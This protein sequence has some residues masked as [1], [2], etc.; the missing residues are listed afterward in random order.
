MT[1]IN[2][3]VFLIISRC[4]KVDIDS[5]NLQSS[6]KDFERWDSLSNLR[7]LSEIE[8]EFGKKINFGK[9][10]RIKTIKELITLISK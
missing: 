7:I 9:L 8:R 10:F 3:K 2:K 1:E 5:I 6:P 4:I